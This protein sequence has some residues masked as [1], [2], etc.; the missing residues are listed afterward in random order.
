MKKYSLT[1]PDAIKQLNSTREE[2]E[3][4]LKKKSVY[5]AN[6]FSERPGT[7]NPVLGQLR[8]NASNNNSVYSNKSSNRILR[9]ELNN[10]SQLLNK[11]AKDRERLD[12]VHPD[13]SDKEMSIKDFIDERSMEGQSRVLR[14]GASESSLRNNIKVGKGQQ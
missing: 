1:G 4:T 14:S 2:V 9:S 5:M 12:T 11:P 3:A 13:N 7:N 8:R 10:R 6:S